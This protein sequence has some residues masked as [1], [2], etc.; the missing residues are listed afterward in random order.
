MYIPSHFEES[1]QARISELVNEYAFAT[2]VT[3]KAGLPFASHLPVMAENDDRQTIVGHMARANEQW[4]HFQANDEVLVMFQ[5][6]HAYISPSNYEGDGVPTWNYASVHMY[7]VARVVDDENRLKDIIESL[8]HKYERS[9]ASPWVSD[10]PDKMLKAI[11]GFEI[12]INRVEAKYKLS[13]NRSAVDRQNIITNLSGSSDS[14][15]KAIAK[16]MQESEPST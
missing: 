8:S 13:Q 15:G 5:G 16:L 12:E 2:M 14:S 7:G 10:Y 1:D 11:V 3:V 6:P 4:Q 9:Q